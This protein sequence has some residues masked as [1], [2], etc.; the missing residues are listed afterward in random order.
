[1]SQITAFVLVFL[2][3]PAFAHTISLKN[4]LSDEDVH[5]KQNC[6]VGSCCVGCLRKNIIYHSSFYYQ[7]NVL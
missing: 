1:V 4:V 5:N 6:D 3:N 2:V 7:M